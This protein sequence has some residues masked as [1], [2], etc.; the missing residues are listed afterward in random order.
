MTDPTPLDGG[1]LGTAL[2]DRVRDERPDLDELVRVATRAGTRLRR[3]RRIAAVV[4]ATAGVAAVAVGAA[5]LTG[6]GG[7]PRGEP[8]LATQ[9]TAA[10]SYSADFGQVVRETRAHARA[11]KALQHASVYVDSPAWRCDR[12]ADE[13]FICSQGSASVVVT[14]RPAWEWDDYQD[15]A[16]AGEETYVSEVHGQLFA[17]VAPGQ[18]T[19]RAQVDE[20]GGALIWA[21]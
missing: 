17:T 5:L 21:E 4:G 9:P 2:H 20:V 7:A 19:T 6:S 15:P 16:K 1:P 13:K 8:G 11:L 18:G 3:R 12:P 10:S 14:W